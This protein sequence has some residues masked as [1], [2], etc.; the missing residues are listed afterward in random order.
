MSGYS[1]VSTFMLLL[2]T[3]FQERRQPKIIISVWPFSFFYHSY[4]NLK[5]PKKV[6]CNFSFESFPFN[7]ISS[8]SIHF[9]SRHKQQFIFLV[10]RKYPNIYLHY[11]YHISV[12]YQEIHTYAAKR[13]VNCKKNRTA[14]EISHWHTLN[15]WAIHPA[16]TNPLL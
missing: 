12:F 8:Y 6:L 11:Q 16:P 14:Y 3:Q 9:S 4:R 5:Y 13:C 15:E 10:G 1:L 2:S 7:Q